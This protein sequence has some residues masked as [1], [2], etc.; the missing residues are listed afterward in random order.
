ML[1]TGNNRKIPKMFTSN[2]TRHLQ[3]RK[4]SFSSQMAVY[5]FKICGAHFYPG[6]TRAVW[7]DVFL[8]LHKQNKGSCMIIPS[9]LS[10]HLLPPQKYQIPVFSEH[11]TKMPWW[12]S[13]YYLTPSL[14]IAPNTLG[15]FNNRGKRHVLW[16]VSVQ[17]MRHQA[18]TSYGQH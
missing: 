4:S 18:R 6:F 7:D 14:N 15:V 2:I 10:S 17:Y 12:Q 3:K 9:S 1:F 8:L 13:Y 5:V 11:Q 16:T